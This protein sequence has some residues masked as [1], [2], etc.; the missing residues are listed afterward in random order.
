MHFCGSV[1]LTVAR[2]SAS[3]LT[4]IL[5]LDVFVKGREEREMSELR[6]L[7]SARLEKKLPESSLVADY[8]LVG[9]KL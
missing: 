2:I 1:Y 6:V 4:M 3:T 8:Q 5:L 7:F 9:V